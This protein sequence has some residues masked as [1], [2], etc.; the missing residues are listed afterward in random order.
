MKDEIHL[1]SDE[2]LNRLAKYLNYQIS[3]I[4]LVV[5][6]A[7]TFVFIFLAALAAIIFTPYMLYVLNKEKK[8]NWII[9][10][11]ILVIV[12]LI[13]LS[14]IAIL[15]PLYY[16]AAPLISIILFYLYCFLLRFEVNEW[17]RGISA[18]NQWLLEKHERDEELN[19]FMKNIE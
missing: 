18:R 3:T 4:I 19:S 11:I 10:F 16:I 12:P 17:L 15:F 6:S 9:F 14:V 1:I 7:F 13:I 2:Q 8:T 5:L